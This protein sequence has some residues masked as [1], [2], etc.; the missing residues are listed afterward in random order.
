MCLFALPSLT[1]AFPP[2]G[3]LMVQNG[4][5]SS[6]LYIHIHGRKLEEEGSAYR[7]KKKKGHM[8]AVLAPLMEASWN[9]TTSVYFSFVT[10]ICKRG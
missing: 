9:L 4:C 10:S 2:Q 1:C 6:N 8:L 5:E 7:L 3:C